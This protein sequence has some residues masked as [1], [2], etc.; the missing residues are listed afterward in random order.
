MH[1][2][3]MGMTKPCLNQS[4]TWNAGLSTNRSA[5]FAAGRFPCVPLS[6][7]LP[8]DPVVQCSVRYSPCELPLTIPLIHNHRCRWHTLIILLLNDHTGPYHHQGTWVHSDMCCRRPVECPGVG[9]GGIAHRMVNC[10][11]NRRFRSYRVLGNFHH[12]AGE[13]EPKRTFGSEV[14]IVRLFV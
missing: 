14:S 10:K 11:T 2:R 4:E 9:V 1:P 13:D 6:L 7:C 5:C 3:M 8:V 12:S